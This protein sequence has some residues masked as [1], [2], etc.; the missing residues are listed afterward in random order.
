M[1][2]WVEPVGRGLG[3]VGSRPL[4]AALAYGRHFD[5]W[6]T[7]L[8]EAIAVVRSQGLLDC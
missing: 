7:Q 6:A 4:L 8:G 2:V 1:K 3:W 5:T